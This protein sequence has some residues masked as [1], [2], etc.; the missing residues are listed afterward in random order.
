MAALF[1]FTVRQSLRLRR[2]WFV[3]LLLIGPSGLALVVRHFDVTDRLE[4]VWKLYQI[5]MLFMLLMVVLPLT[6]ML[7]GSTLIASEAEGGTLV[8]L[9]TRRMRRETVLLVRFAAV[10]GVLTV[11]LGLAFSAFHLCATAGLDIDRLNE[12]A[13]MTRENAWNPS[14]DL[15]SYLRV[16][17][18]AVAAFLAVFTLISLLFKRPLIISLGYLV[19]LEMIVG[20]APVRAQICTITHQ[21]RRMVKASI[22]DLLQALGSRHARMLIEPF[23]PPGAT[24]LIPL[25]AL[26]IAALGLACLAMRTREPVPAKASRE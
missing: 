25:V 26:V 5:P 11:L 22:P 18:L 16:I 23:Y 17:P 20:N 8:Y 4:G 2:L 3:V 12:A 7:H 24:G 15:F 10:W 6:C 21:L 14:H 19:I 9:I 13:E 1:W